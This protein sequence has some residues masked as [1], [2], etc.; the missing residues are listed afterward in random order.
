MKTVAS[1]QQIR[2]QRDDKSSDH[3]PTVST[4]DILNTK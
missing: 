4:S 3:L 1:S 2:L